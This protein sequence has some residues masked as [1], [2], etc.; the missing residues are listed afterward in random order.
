M[1]TMQKPLLSISMLVSNNIETIEKCME[2]LKPLLQGFP[3]ELVVVDTVG[4]EHTDGSLDVVRRYTDKIYRFEWCND[5]AAARNFGLNKCTGEWFMFLDDD[6][7]FEDV[8]EIVQFFTSGEYK[9][10]RCAMYKIHDY[11]NWNGEYLENSKLRMVKREKYTQFVEPVHEYLH[12]IQAP[13]KEFSAYIHHY[14]YVFDTEEDRRKHSERNL[15]LLLPEFEKNPWNMHVRAQLIQEYLTLRNTQE[16]DRLCEDTLSASKDLY[17]KSYFQWILTTY[18]RSALMAKDWNGV[19]E[20]AAML[21]KKFPLND[22]AELAIS[23]EELRVHCQ[24][25]Q[26]EEGVRA[27]ERL[28]KKRKTLINNPELKL[29]MICLD[30]ENYLSHS[31]YVTQLTHGIYCYR[32]T[33]DTVKA[34]KFCKEYFSLS[35]EPVLTISVLVSNRIHTI[36]K[37]MESLQKLRKTVP[38]ELLVVDTV[39][40]KDSDGS[41]VI[42]REYADRVIPFAWENDFS[43]ARNAGLQQ[44][45]GSWFLYLDD[46]EW[47][48]STEEIQKFFTSGEYLQYNSAAYQIRNYVD[49]EGTSYNAVTVHRMVH[50]TKDTWFTGCINEALEPIFSPVKEL[51]DFAHH[52]GFVYDTEEQKHIRLRMVRQLMEQDLV[53]YPAYLPNRSKLAIVLSLENP[54]K[55]LEICQETLELCQKDHATVTYQEQIVLQFQLLEK[56]RY[57]ATAADEHYAKLQKEKM[58]QPVT[59]QTVCY[60]MVRLFAVQG[61]YRKSYWYAKRYFAL[62][63]II[64]EEHLKIATPFVKYQT[65]QRRQEMLELGGITAW[66][67]EEYEDA[68]E[69]YEAMS[70]ETMDGSSEETMSYLCALVKE[71]LDTDVFYRILKRIMGNPALKPLLAVQM[72]DIELKERINHTLAMQRMKNEYK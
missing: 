20:R 4:E 61:V 68:W 45:K 18:V 16:G 7:W 72:Q 14:G 11:I 63:G 9:K 64:Y 32:M 26:Y 69:C 8:T 27:F 65:P 10:Y 60:H 54:D 33:G 44:A 25:K 51:T 19:L 35:S 40:E 42:A 5:F 23:T 48:E 47:F 21:R 57:D 59:E 70:W 53:K 41:L 71:H 34:E 67:S 31:M 28:M 6:E 46:D 24:L 22:L 38:C 15:N 58:I 12:G 56:L 2:S 30:L 37:C 3:C 52:Y 50:R 55:A 1:E 43:V 17:H 13:V 66:Q 49:R 29:R 39:G 36:R 62:E